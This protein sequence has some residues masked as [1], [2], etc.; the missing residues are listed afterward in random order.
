M[1]IRLPVRSSSTQS[2]VLKVD[3][4]FSFAVGLNGFAVVGYWQGRRVEV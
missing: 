3:G 4:S 1:S 2:E